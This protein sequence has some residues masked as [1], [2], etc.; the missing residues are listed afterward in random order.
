MKCRVLL[1][2]MLTATFL[3]SV[4]NLNAQSSALFDL[5][6]PAKTG[7][8]FINNVNDS[9]TK[10]ILIYANFYG[11]AG[12][13]VI[14]INNDGLQDLFFAG[15]LVSNVLY[16]NEGN[17]KFQDIT[18]EAG[19]IFDGG[20]STGVTVA[21]VNNDGYDDIYVSRELYD[22]EPDLRANLL[23][24][25]NQDNT[26]TEKAE[27]YG[28]ADKQRTRHATFLDYNKDGFLDLF[29]LTQ[30]PNPGSYSPYSGADLKKQEYH[31][32]LYKNING[33][34]FEEVSEQAGVAISGFPNGVSASDLNNDGWT[35]LYVSNDFAAPDFLF[36]N[37]KDG[38]FTNKM[39]DAFMHIP[40]YSMGVDVAD[41]NNDNLLDVFVVDM[42]AKDNFRLKSNMSGMNPKSFWKVV[43]NGGYYQYMYN[44]VQLSNGNGSFSDIGQYTGMAATDWSWANLIADFDND[45]L[46]DAYVTNGLL[47]DIRNTDADKAV[48][49][50]V[51]KV[52]YDWVQKHPD[53]G[54]ITSIWDIL[55]IEDVLKLI[56][57]KPLEN[58]AFK[59]KGNLNF[60]ESQKNWGLD[61]VS[62][63]NGAAYVDLDNDG[64]LD[65]VV[66]NINTEAFIYRNNSDKKEA[67][68]YIRIKPVDSLNTTILGTRVTLYN[69]EHSQLQEMTNVRG[70]YSTSEQVAHFGLG[71]ITVVDSVIVNWPSGKESRLYNLQANQQ[72]TVDMQYAKN[73]LPRAETFKA[74]KTYFQDVTSTFPLQIK[75]PEN[76]YDDFEEQ[77]LLPHKLSQFGPALAK[78]D[79]NNDGLEDIFVG[80]ASGISASLFKQT[81]EGSFI[82]VIAK[83]LEADLA[84]EDLDALFVDIN[85]D[86]FL[87]LYVVSGGN[88]KDAG[89]SFYEDRFYLNDTR[90]NFLKSSVANSGLESGSKVI[91]GDYDGDGDLDLFVGGRLK[92]HQYPLPATSALL[93][94][95]NGVLRNGTSEFAPQLKDLG[96]VTDA[97]FTDF[98][99]DGDL[100]LLVVGEWMPITLFENINNR[101]I[102]KVDETLAAT[103]GW[104]FS[105]EKADFDNDGDD[106]YILGNLGKNYK[107]QTVASKPFDIYYNDFDDNGKGDIVLGYYDG[108]KHYPL[109]GFSCSS[110]QI[111]SLKT[112]IKKY[113]IFASL[114]I[115]EVYGKGELENSLHYISNTFASVYLENKN[116]SFVIHEL[117]VAA[118]LAPITDIVISDFNVDGKLDAVVA[119]NMFG[120]EIETPRAD[121]GTGVLLLGDGLGNFKSESI[122]TSGFFARG[123]VKK[124]L[125]IRIK[126]SDY[127]LVGNNNDKLQVF[128]TSD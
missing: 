127:I 55:K 53:G 115:D 27:L 57:S 3:F 90:G 58:F 121:S 44:T 110:E 51:N 5:L 60:E 113:D 16:L 95:E 119:G 63:S 108:D 21:D 29:L 111:P 28:V 101:L 71:S 114:E 36:I 1:F 17:F 9:Q 13:G 112:E 82:K 20:W 92:P 116:N 118:Q 47:R 89:D 69:G 99:K 11:G 12:V 65:L 125:P 103:S 43:D 35:D 54:G 40:Y 86:G 42:V 64:D 96:M 97:V 79:F 88:E 32:K 109:R 10:N 39:E 56:P 23:Y 75:T 126:E 66:N 107:Y 105:I 52:S 124:L 106:D 102:K 91:S 117:P 8:N 73:I 37:N 46:K 78:G 67:S 25:N 72:I 104:W 120:S 7:V 62:F 15:N 61:Q 123:D 84:H 26:F 98:D 83:D 59:N 19:I 80:G 87:D 122:Q 81:K 77:V 76:S 2:G 38:S 68:N 128:K 93:I 100:D 4:K 45:G 48:A 94:N 18:N 41:L 85:G 30:P 70:I 50:H 31:I 34:F 74:S 6:P 22:N 33:Q 49:A 14:D 24:I